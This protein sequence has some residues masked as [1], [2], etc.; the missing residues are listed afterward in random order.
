MSYCWDITPSEQTVSQSQRFTPR[1]TFEDYCFRYDYTPHQSFTPRTTFEDY[2]YRYDSTPSQQTVSQS[3]QTNIYPYQI[4]QKNPE[5]LIVKNISPNKDNLDRLHAIY[6]WIPDRYQIRPSEEVIESKQKFLLQIGNVSINIYIKKYIFDNDP[7]YS[8]KCF[9]KENMFP[10]ATQ[11]KHYVLW[12]GIEGF[13][14][15][16]S[17]DQI[18][19]DISINIEKVVSREAPGSVFDFCW[20]VNPDI[21]SNPERHISAF[22]HVH[23]FWI[24]YPN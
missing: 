12:Y 9:F 19:T 8:I 20:Y 7:D 5:P 16:P 11:G 13:N 17:N 18:T 3:Q 14:N 6:Y 4:P 2:C 15:P 21:L 10:Y 23:V 22:F 24:I 1:T